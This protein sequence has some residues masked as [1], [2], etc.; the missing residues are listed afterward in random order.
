MSP[1]DDRLAAE[2]AEHRR[3]A[4]AVAYRMVGSFGDAEDV[5][6]EAF[7]RLRAALE[8]GTE[9][10]DVRAYLV[11]ITT[12]LA[13]DHLKSARVRRERYVG[14]WLPEPAVEGRTDLAEEVA[15][16][17]SL[18]TA[19][20]VL[21][22]R[23]TPE[24]R[25]VLLLRDVFDHSF[26]EVA[27]ILGR[28]EEACRQLAVRARRRVREER[29]RFHPARAEV[30]D[31]STRFFAA[32]RRGDVDGLV[33]LL[34]EDAEFVG[35]GG[36]SRRG[37]TRVLTGPLEVARMVSAGLRRVVELGADLEPAWV[38]GQPAVLI[39]DPEGALVGVWSLV[40]DRTE[41]RAV[42]GMVNPDKLGHLGLELTDWATTTRRAGPS[43]ERPHE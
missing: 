22:E 3:A 21:L 34:A 23:L 4:L 15:L 18:S 1:S 9:P 2:Y 10:D 37:V 30:E 38:G 20:L 27:E 17:D 12:R 41:V 24:Q 31:L 11:T 35:D 40:V 42:H 33:A 16:A 25:A 5:V 6:Q 43:S 28:S 32:A 7:L 29:P 26:A 14:P 39:I 13:I 36:D 19:F 8:R